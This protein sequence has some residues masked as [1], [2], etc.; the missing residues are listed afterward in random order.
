[1]SDRV[2][3]SN[4]CLHGFHGVHNAEKN[5]GQKFYLDMDCELAGPATTTDLMRDTVDYG[6]L[7]DLA[8]KLSE[9]TVFNLIETFAERIAQAVLDTQPL[10]KRV[11]V[12]VRKPSAPIRHFVDHVGVAVTRSRN[13]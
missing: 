8:A 9:E 13:A 5:L 12:T 6:A 2:F 11:T 10:V 7:C 1:M 4:L 3:V